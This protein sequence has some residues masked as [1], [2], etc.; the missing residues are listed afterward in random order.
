MGLLCPERQISHNAVNFSFPPPLRFAVLLLLGHENRLRI[1][2][3]FSPGSR[4]VHRATVLREDWQE[5]GAGAVPR[6]H[7][8]F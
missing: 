6:Y 5:N 8:V 2:I 4:D 7:I 1:P 3:D